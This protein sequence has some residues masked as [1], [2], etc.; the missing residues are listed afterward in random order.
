MSKY[1]ALISIEDKR[2]IPL[3]VVA[4]V[5]GIKAGVHPTKNITDISML[6]VENQKTQP[7]CVG[8]AEGKDAEYDEYIETGKVTR[9]SKRWLYSLCKKEDGIYNLPGTYPTIAAKLRVSTGLV[10]EELLPDNND[11]PYKEYINIKITNDLLTDASSTRAKGFSFVKTLDEVKT[12]I[13]ISKKFTA[14]LQ[15]GDWS[16][17]PVKPILKNGLNDG[18]HRIWIIGYEDAKNKTKQDTKIYY[19]NS[20]GI[21][22]A[23]G[24]NSAD[25]KLLK[26]GIGYFW[27]SEYSNYFY[28]GIVYLDMP[29]EIID[30]AK[31][32]T[33][34]FSR[35]LKRGMTGTDIIELQ[36]RLDR[37]L[38]KDGKKCYLAEYYDANFGPITEK[39]VKR[40]QEAKG[41]TSDGVVGKITLAEL[42][43]QES[44]SDLSLLNK[45]AD[46]IQWYEGWYA[47]SRSYRNNN[48]GNIRYIG[49][50]RATGKD[51]AG[52]CI[53]ANYQDGRQELVDLLVRASSGKSSIYNPE[54]TLLEFYQKYAPSSDGNYPQTYA[55]AVA[56]R[57]GVS[58]DIKIKN[59][60]SGTTSASVSKGK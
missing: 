26:K 41:L 56:K 1:G 23:K 7:S 13:D 45:W 5:M 20:W 40:Y 16:A 34:I 60:L 39:S 53:F 2:N 3:S 43:K 4:S 24:K 47:G 11:L 37:E 50:K 8:Q 57:M 28:D 25:K 17:L 42:N 38:G 18:S 52:F 32:Q 9:L 31:S 55:K 29:N 19:L 15:V 12:A 51:S 35:T 49:Q 10:K 21:E 36:K 30:Y 27:W 58:V 59:I 54:M 6:S 14:T 46:A 33:Y 48:P 44:Y 22:W